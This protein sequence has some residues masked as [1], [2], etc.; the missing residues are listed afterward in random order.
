MIIMIEEGASGLWYGVSGPGG[1][2]KGL[3]IA[4]KT[5]D[6][7]LDQVSPVVKALRDAALAAAEE[8]IKKQP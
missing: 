1:P 4:G 6:E 7:V 2:Y 3:L 5:L 8:A